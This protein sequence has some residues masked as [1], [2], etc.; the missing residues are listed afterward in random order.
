M[1]NEEFWKSVKEARVKQD[2]SLETISR[3]TKIGIQILE[4]IESGD[5]SN[6]SETYMRLFLKAY[7]RETGNDYDQ[8]LENAPFSR[9][10]DT[11]KIYSLQN[12]DDEKQYAASIANVKHEKVGGFNARKARPMYIII[13]ILVALFVIYIGKQVISES[14][15]E[16]KP[17]LIDSFQVVAQDSITT[18][19]SSQNTASLSENL[20]ATKEAE[21]EAITT[22]YSF[23]VTVNL[24]PTANII[25]RLVING[26]TPKEELIQK[27]K[28]HSFT[29]NKSFVLTVYNVKNCSISL[30]SVLLPHSTKER[31]K[32]GID[33]DGHLNILD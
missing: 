2:I 11:Q 8:L 16:N 25:Y 10:R 3:N 30:N 1:S 13:T 27:D 4:N 31:L 23:P 20:S 15:T 29:V 9:D 24:F 5:F 33:A 6:L 32:F 22:D 26:E 19:D 18:A 7:A 28:D 14:E 21:T 17:N 12:I